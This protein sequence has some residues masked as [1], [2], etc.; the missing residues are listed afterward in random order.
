MVRSGHEHQR[1]L[2]GVRDA[3]ADVGLLLVG[4]APSPIEGGEGNREFLFRLVPAAAPG[5]RDASA[6]IGNDMLDAIAH[7]AVEGAP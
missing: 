1:V 5:A 3:A 2:R 4:A 6:A 7:P